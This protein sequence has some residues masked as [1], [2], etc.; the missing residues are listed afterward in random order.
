MEDT[1]QG[2]GVA[3]HLKTLNDQQTT[4]VT[5]ITE[6]TSATVPTSSPSVVETTGEATP[7]REIGK[8][9]SEHPAETPEGQ[10]PAGGIHQGS[11]RHKESKHDHYGGEQKAKKQKKRIDLVDPEEDLKNA[12]YYIDNGKYIYVMGEEQ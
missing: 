5:P 2:H 1:L 10:V 4:D 7:I 8:E 9:A 11:K 3:E 12:Q 6:S